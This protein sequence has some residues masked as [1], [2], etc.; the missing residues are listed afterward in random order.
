MNL[1]I[2]VYV[3]LVG[4]CIATFPATEG[5]AQHCQPYW[6]AQ[7]KCAMGCGPCDGGVGKV[8]ALTIVGAHA[9]Q[10]TTIEIVS[11]GIYTL[12]VTQSERAASGLLHN[13]FTNIRHA[14]TT[15]TIP[16]RQGVNFGFKFHVTGWPTGQTVEFRKVALFP[17]PGLKSPTSAEPMRKDEVKLTE[18][19]GETSYTGYTFDDPWELVP[20]EWTFQLW[21]GNRELAEKTFT[22]VAHKAKILCTPRQGGMQCSRP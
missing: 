18:T 5:L 16:A 9:R 22:V 1:R 8:A 19:I 11:Y 17:A 15:T 21:S 14:A 12:D 6:A 10:V 3:G 2:S 13:T 20:G 4:F 7:Y